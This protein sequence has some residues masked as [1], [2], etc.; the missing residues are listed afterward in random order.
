MRVCFRWG[1]NDGPVVTTVNQ[2][3]SSFSII[4]DKEKCGECDYNS[5]NYDYS[6][7]RGQYDDRSYEG[8]CYDGRLFIG[9]GVGRVAR[10][11]AFQ[12]CISFYAPYVARFDCSGGMVAEN[13]W[14]T[15]TDP[16]TGTPPTTTP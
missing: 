14:E 5:E 2:T 15:V 13:Y 7:C 10:N 12:Q 4:L 8:G 9:Q 11:N 1:Y 16:L 6:G 3:D